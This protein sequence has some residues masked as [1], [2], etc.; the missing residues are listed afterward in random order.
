M[1]SILGKDGSVTIEEIKTTVA[2]LDAFSHDHAEW[3][4]SQAMFYADIL[5]EDRHVDN[6]TIVLTYI[7]QNDYKKKRRSKSSSRKGTGLLCRRF[8]L[9]ICQLHGQ[10]PGD[11]GRKEQDVQGPSFPLS[12]VAERPEKDDGIR[13]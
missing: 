8:D 10:D 11:E 13:P 6:V 9:R 4:L 7:K 5:A 1:A 12:I 3:H 2:D